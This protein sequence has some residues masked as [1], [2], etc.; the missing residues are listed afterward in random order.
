[1]TLIDVFLAVRNRAWILFSK[2]PQ[3]K[4]TNVCQSLAERNFIDVLRIK[5]VILTL[6]ERNEV[7]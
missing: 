2:F 4:P 6:R 1:M 5:M 3:N 7:L